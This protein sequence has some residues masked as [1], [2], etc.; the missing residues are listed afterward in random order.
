MVLYHKS[1]TCHMLELEEPCTL[2]LIT[3]PHSEGI[4]F[5]FGVVLF[6]FSFLL[7]IR[8]SS[9]LSLFLSTKSTNLYQILAIIHKIQQ[10]L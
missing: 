3:D 7:S 5:V 10:L 2:Q 1:H 6:L 8:S 9:F 4:C